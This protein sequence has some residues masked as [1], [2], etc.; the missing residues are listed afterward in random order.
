MRRCQFEKKGYIINPE[1]N[2]Y[3]WF[4]SFHFDDKTKKFTKIVG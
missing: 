3:S 2:Y 4:D 1:F